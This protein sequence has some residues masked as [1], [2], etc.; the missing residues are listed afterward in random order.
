[1]VHKVNRTRKGIRPMKIYN[2]LSVLFL[3][4]LSAKSLES[5]PTAEEALSAIQEVLSV[6]NKYKLIT[7][8]KEWFLAEQEAVF[9][10]NEH[11]R[12]VP[13]K[14][15]II[16]DFSY[17]RNYKR[18]LGLPPDPYRV[19]G[20]KWFNMK[21]RIANTFLRDMGP[22]RQKQRGVRGNKVFRDGHWRFL[23]TQEAVSAINEHNRV[24]TPENK[25]ISTHSYVKNHGLIPGLPSKLVLHGRRYWYS[26]NKEKVISQV[27]GWVDGGSNPFGNKVFRD[28]HRQF[29]TTRWAVNA[30]KEHNQTAPVANRILSP[31]SHREN[32][33]LIPGLP[34]K[35]WV[36]YGSVAWEK[37]LQEIRFDYYNNDRSRCAAQFTAL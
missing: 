11:N 31:M 7:N 22:L 27:I 13:V 30:I 32:H 21:D 24:A 20:D 28:E 6:L 14:S 8:G 34:Q 15:K 25:I 5:A 10:I 26:P 12:I 33:G 17:E 29:L 2:F 36:Y 1:M 9:A 23:T 19:Y 18:I 16:S 37:M 3:F 35:P 4:C